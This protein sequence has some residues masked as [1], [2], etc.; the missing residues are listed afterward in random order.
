MT[1]LIATIA[2]DNLRR[3]IAIAKITAGPTTGHPA[4]AN[5]H[6]TISESGNLVAQSTD[7]YILSRTRIDGSHDR[8]D[9]FSE[10]GAALPVRSATF[11]E[12]WL[13]LVPR[14]TDIT[15]EIN[16]AGEFSFSADDAPTIS[17]IPAYD[18]EYPAIGPLAKGNEKWNVY[19]DD[20]TGLV[21]LNPYHFQRIGKIGTYSGAGDPFMIQTGKKKIN[22]SPTFAF[23]F[24][25][26]DDKV[27]CDGMLMGVR[28]PADS[29]GIDGGL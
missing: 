24:I 11:V 13:P 18:D 9:D 14:G 5:I 6:F 20:R 2:K 16:D 17:G 4:L 29:A 21:A 10:K 3:A 7:R 1:K 8:R 19:A 27:W 26:R 12:K 25:D 23:R 28:Y 15:L 22:E